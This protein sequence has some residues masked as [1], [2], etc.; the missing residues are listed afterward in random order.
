MSAVNK[1]TGQWLFGL[2]ILI[3]GVIFLLENLFGYEIWES[4]WLFWPLIFILWGLV[5]IFQKKSIFFGVILLAIGVIFV[6]KNFNIYLISESIW[7]F[8]P[9]IIIAIGVDQVFKKS[10]AGHF[11]GNIKNRKNKKEVIVQDDEII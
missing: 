6:A 4:V 1:N 11:K 8:W 7:R 2:I 5:E 10:Q 3:I 9:V